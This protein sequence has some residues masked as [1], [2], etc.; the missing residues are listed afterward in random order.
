[1]KKEINKKLKIIELKIGLIIESLKNNESP[2]NVIVQIS[3]A[4]KKLRIVRHLILED[5]LIKT[6]EK[7]GLPKEEILKYYKLTN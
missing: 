2:E 1:M 4:Q 5:H 3:K 7:A 6:A